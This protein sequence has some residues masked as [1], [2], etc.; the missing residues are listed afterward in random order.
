MRI[1][2][3]PPASRWRTAL[4]EGPTSATLPA[5]AGLAAVEITWAGAAG[6]HGLAATLRL[7]VPVVAGG[8][9]VVRMPTL[10]YPPKTPSTPKMGNTG[11][12]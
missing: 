6:P 3:P 8:E 5:P 11:R 2:T 9:T 10:R 1:S 7:R 12:P 4:A